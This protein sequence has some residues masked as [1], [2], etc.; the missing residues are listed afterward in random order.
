MTSGYM[1]KKMS[2]DRIL[3]P[4]LDN[5]DPLFVLLITPGS[6]LHHIEAADQDPARLLVAV[7][8]QEIMK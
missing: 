1:A 6:Y 4:T 5:A 2:I 7:Y 8:K 3:A